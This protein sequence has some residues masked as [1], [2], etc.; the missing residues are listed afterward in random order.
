MTSLPEEAFEPGTSILCD[1]HLDLG[2]SDPS[3][4]FETVLATLHGSPR[5]VILGDLFDY[6]VGP[7]QLGLAGAPRILDA[8]AGLSASGT[9][10]DVLFGNRDFLLDRHF[11]ERTG[12]T[13]RP[14]GMIGVLP[15]GRRSLLIHGDELCTRDIGYQRLKRVLRSRF[16][17]GLAP[18]LPLALSERLARRLRR[19]STAALQIKP[20]EEKTMQRDACEKL[21]RE[22]EAQHVICGHAHAYRDE[23]LEGGS[24]WLVLDAFGGA[25]D[26]LTLG[27]EEWEVRGSCESVSIPRE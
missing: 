14:R 3:P 18:R 7:A 22:C 12:A 11:A 9:R 27:S 16:V 10:L 13:L 25:R 20:S 1:L 19:A 5:L 24:R 17:Q 21:A 26:S 6:W 8:M 15:D 23:V 2:K 4:E